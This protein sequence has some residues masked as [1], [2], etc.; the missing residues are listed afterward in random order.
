MKRAPSH[1]TVAWLVDLAD[2]IVECGRL[3]RRAT[4]EVDLHCIER[5]LR[6]DLGTAQR[7]AILKRLV[8]EGRLSR[9]RVAA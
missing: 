8:E 3:P 9:T 4:G 1:S 7:V 2:A 6:L 5:I